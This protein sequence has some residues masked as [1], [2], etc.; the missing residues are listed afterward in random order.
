MR[1]LCALASSL[2]LSA[3]G[4]SPAEGGSLN[5]S[6]VAPPA[7][8]DGPE[9]KA[10]IETAESHPPQYTLVVDINCPTGGFALQLAEFDNQSTPREAKFILTSPA[11]DELV[12]QA[13]QNH[14]ERVDL[15]TERTPVRVLVSQRQR[16]NPE[17]DK[18]P[19]QLATSV[20]PR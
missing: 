20:T 7:A 2:V 19:F 8:Y 5:G 18:Q 10:T 15:G 12:I 14:V 3:C 6:T 4:C 17:T 16:R 11:N 1:I 13:F 9:L